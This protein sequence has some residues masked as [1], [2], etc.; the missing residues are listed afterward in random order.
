MTSEIEEKNV[1]IQ[2]HWI[3]KNTNKFSNKLLSLF[4]VCMDWL[5]DVGRMMR[6]IH[7]QKLTSKWITEK[8]TELTEVD[9]GNS[10]GSVAKK[11]NI[12]NSR[13]SLK[14]DAFKLAQKEETDLWTSWF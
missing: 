10:C 9:R 2:R 11:Y 4:T 12:P 14:A 13:N 1:W 6:I 7:K 8:Y 5:Q 3:E